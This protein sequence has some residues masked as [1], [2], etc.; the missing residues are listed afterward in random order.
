MMFQTPQ[1]SLSDVEHPAGLV[2]DVKFPPILISKQNDF[3]EEIWS[4]RR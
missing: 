3:E 4:V 1:E 2:N